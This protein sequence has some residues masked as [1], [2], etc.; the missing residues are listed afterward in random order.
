MLGF[1]VAQL[2]KNPP[3]MW[4][5]WVRSL[6]W[7]DPLEKGKATHSIILAWRIPLSLHYCIVVV[8]S[9]SRVWLLATPSTAAH[10][11]PLSMGILQARILEWI[12]YP[13]SRG[14]SQPRD[15]TQVSCIAGRF[16]TPWVTREDLG[17]NSYARKWKSLS[18]VRLFTTPWTIQSMEFSRPEYGSG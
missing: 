8:Q 13:F 18:H 9:L 4:E 7:E 12:S 14:S 1:L 10:Q 6:G 17:H 15:W 11:A 16:F 5:T 2:V 3:A